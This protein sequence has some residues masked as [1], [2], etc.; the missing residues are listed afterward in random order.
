MERLLLIQSVETAR[1]MEEGVVRRAQDADVGAVLGWGYPALRG[2]PIGWIHTLGIPE[3][4]TACE[5]LAE[6]AG[7]RSFRPNC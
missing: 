1:C 4:V 7:P 3:F 5:R 6:H 2:G